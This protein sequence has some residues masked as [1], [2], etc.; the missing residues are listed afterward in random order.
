MYVIN[1]FKQYLLF[2]I[3]LFVLYN[4]NAQTLTLNDAVNTG[5]DNYGMVK[6]KA[7]YQKAAQQTIKEVQRSYLPNFNLAAQQTYGTI[8]GQNGPQYGSGGLG[9]AS[10]GM[11]LEDQNW[12]AAFGALYLANINWDFFTF[13]RINSQIKTAKIK[14]LQ[15]EKDT[16]QERFKHKVKIASSYLNLLASHRLLASQKR[17]LER[18]LVMHNNAATQVKNGLLPGVDSTLTAAE[19]SRAKISLN[20]L[21][22]KLKTQN[23]ELAN[24]MGIAAQNF[25]IDTSLVTKTP[26]LSTSLKNP[27][28]HPVLDFYKSKVDV[29]KSELDIYKKSNLPIFSLFGVFQTR[30]SGFSSAY[31]TNQNLYT[32]NYF[33]GIEPSRHNYLFGLSARWNLTDI[34]RN[35][36]KIT[37]QKFKIQGLEEEYKTINNELSTQI[38]AANN[39]LKITLENYK[40]APIQVK[41]AQQAYTQRLA[42]YNNGLTNL[43]DVTQALYTLNR[44]ETDLDII[45]TNVWQAL[46]LKAASTGNFD[47]FINQINK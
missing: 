28:K 11:P 3:G 39:S 35:A 22:Q 15:A 20:Q 18:A 31:N 7:H 8:N 41:A 16:E 19:V 14:A 21:K 32:S 37:A 4:T 44:A 17:N 27:S 26:L 5:M 13:G 42:L 47:L 23:N 33:D 1:Y 36:K 29:G 10:S 45:N 46:L 30:G 2:F 25:K 34:T 12:N 38:D 43:V 40:E 6:A 24:F 9:S